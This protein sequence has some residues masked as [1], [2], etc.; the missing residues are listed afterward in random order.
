MYQML[1]I[2][3][4]IFVMAICIAVSYALIV[5]FEVG[6]I[7]IETRKSKHCTT[8]HPCVISSSP[9]VE[10]SPSQLWIYDPNDNCDIALEGSSGSAGETSLLQAGPRQTSPCQEDQ[11]GIILQY[12][13][14]KYRHRCK[15]KYKC[16]YML[17]VNT[18]LIL[19]KIKAGKNN[20]APHG[21]YLDHM[22]YWRAKTFLIS[23]H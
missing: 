13:V 21:N 19:R 22:A 20:T 1:M 11:D 5:L 7:S 3:N 8:Q 6:N 17:K 23:V 12:T 9:A 10:I 16:N 18:V 14:Y 4:I 2:Y 15:F